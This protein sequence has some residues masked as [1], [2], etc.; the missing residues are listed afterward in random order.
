MNTKNID[1]SQKAKDYCFLLLKLRLYSQKELYQRLKKKKFDEGIIKETLTFLKERNYIND[2]YFVKS[3]IES[4]IKKPLGLKRLIQELKSK[5]IDNQTIQ[6]QLQ[7][8][9]E[10]Y[11]EKDIVLGI[12]REK[13]G[14]LEGI[15]S[16]KAKRH[17]YEYLVRR[18][19][20]PEVVMDVI[21]QI[22]SD[23]SI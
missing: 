8:I 14:K 9:K 12:A 2:A 1:L 22:Q 20:S 7:R 15:D 21:R 16:Q 4:R 11:C 6:E 10:G 3:W 17:A 5:G 13:I 23:D 18:G 19:F